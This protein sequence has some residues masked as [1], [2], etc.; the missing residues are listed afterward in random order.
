LFSLN[1]SHIS[2]SKSFEGSPYDFWHQKLNL[3]NKEQSLSCYEEM[4]NLNY[5][6]YKD[7]QKPDFVLT[8]IG[9]IPTLQPLLTAQ[10]CIEVS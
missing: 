8:F 5:A 1:Q 3:D 4:S 9:Y 10:N 6:K 2:E 7:W